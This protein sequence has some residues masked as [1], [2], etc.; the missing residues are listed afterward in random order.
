M[1][2][3]FMQ[4]TIDTYFSA[5]FSFT[6]KHVSLFEDEIFCIVKFIFLFMAVASLVIKQNL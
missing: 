2:Q 4:F 5:L 1:Y 3:T 6:C